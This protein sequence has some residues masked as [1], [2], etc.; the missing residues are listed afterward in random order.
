[1]YLIIVCMCIQIFMDYSFLD[2]IRRITTDENY[3]PTVQDVLFARSKTTGIAE[4]RFH[5][6][7]QLTIQ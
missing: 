3:T 1:M 7:N 2:D 4:T 6:G 5:A